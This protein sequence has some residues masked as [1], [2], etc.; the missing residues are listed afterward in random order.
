MFSFVTYGGKI[1]DNAV[2]PEKIFPVNII[3]VSKD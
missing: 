3:F 1:S 2:T